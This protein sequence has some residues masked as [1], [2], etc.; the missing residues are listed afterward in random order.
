MGLVLSGIFLL[1]MKEEDPNSITIAFYNVENLFDTLNDPRTNDNKFIPQSKYVWTSER[2]NQKIR[3]LG[4][5]ISKLGDSDGPEILGL[6]EI[7]NELVLQHL[8]NSKILKSKGYDFIHFDS[9]DRRGIDV[10]LIYKRKFFKPY[11]SQAKSII[12]KQNKN[13]RTR[14]ILVVSGVLRKDTLHFLVNHWPSRIG[15]EEK[16]EI[17][18]LNVAQV[19]RLL[20]D[21][22]LKI[23]KNAKLI[24]MGDFNDT[25]HN[26][27]IFNTLRAKD[28]MIAC[29]ETDLYNPFHR[30]MENGEGT[31]KYKGEWDMLDQIMISKGLLEGKKL[32]YINNSEDTYDPIWMY[33]KG[34]TTHGPFRSYTG[35]KYHGGYSDHFPVYIKLVLSH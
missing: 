12:V 22:L 19:A 7:E 21:S 17:H 1:N 24:V 23:S 9:D 31:Y 11:S 18:R 25:P 10:A 8:V 26:K 3:N 15:G 16:T 6:C 2:Y 35:A 28:E 34:K 5:V 27:S 4:E 29:N 13:F 14:D 30:L 32:K 20:S 33:Y